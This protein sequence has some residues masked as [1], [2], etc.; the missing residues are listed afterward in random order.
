MITHVPKQHHYLVQCDRSGHQM[1]ISTAR[2]E[3][4]VKEVATRWGWAFE[5]AH[6]DLCVRCTKLWK[7]GMIG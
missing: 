7:A 3:Q 5:T 4:R 1:H 2:T 6:G